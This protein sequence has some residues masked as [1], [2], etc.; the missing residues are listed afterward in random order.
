MPLLTDRHLAGFSEFSR[1]AGDFALVMVAVVA[2]VEEGAV[3]DVRIG[4]GGVSDVPV[5][6]TSAE[7]AMTGRP[8]EPATWET[9]AGAGRD[10]V[11]PFEDIHATSEYRRELVSA[12]LRR[13]CRGAR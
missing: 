6:L 13:A 3:A 9:A 7:Q 2:K 11:E 10:E 8:W 1:R 5:R 12:L 4:A